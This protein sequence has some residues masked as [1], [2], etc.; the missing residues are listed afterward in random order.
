MQKQG[1]LLLQPLSCHEGTSHEHKTSLVTGNDAA[2]LIKPYPKLHLHLSIQD[3]PASE[4]SLL[5]FKPQPVKLL[6]K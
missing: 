3:P 2:A 6:E 5:F 4:F 1:L